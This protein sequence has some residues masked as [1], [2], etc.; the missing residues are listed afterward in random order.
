MAAKVA[1]AAGGIGEKVFDVTMRDNKKGDGK[2]KPAQKVQLKVGQMGIQLF[3]GPQLLDSWAY[4]SLGAWEY[5]TGKRELSN[6]RVLSF[7]PGYRCS[8]SQSHTNI[9]SIC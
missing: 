8:P 4:A 7:Y 5:K 2:P 9:L 1:E 3:D 6:L